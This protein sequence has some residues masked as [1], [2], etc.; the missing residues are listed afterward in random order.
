MTQCT[1]QMQTDLLLTINIFIE[2]YRPIS[3]PG[4]PAG[5][6]L[7]VLYRDGNMQVKIR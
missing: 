6:D 1:L 7:P 2:R 4:Y 3:L 5:R